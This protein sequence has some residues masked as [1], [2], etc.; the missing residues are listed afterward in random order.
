MGGGGS[1]FSGTPSESTRLKVERS[2][3]PSSVASK[4][5]RTNTWEKN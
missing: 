2:G 1:R 4:R 3:R 5:K